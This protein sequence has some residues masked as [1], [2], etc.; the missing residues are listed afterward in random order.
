LKTQIKTLEVINPSDY[1][2]ESPIRP[3]FKLSERVLSYPLNKEPGM[4]SEKST[5][6]MN[7]ICEPEDFTPF[8]SN[9]DLEQIEEEKEIGLNHQNTSG[10]SQK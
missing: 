2:K 7:E 1:D 8:K 9:Y 5:I 3:N 4:K 6:S 10:L